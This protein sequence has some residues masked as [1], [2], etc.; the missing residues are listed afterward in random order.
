MENPLRNEIKSRAKSRRPG[1]HVRRFAANF[2]LRG[3]RSII[4]GRPAFTP[5]SAALCR[6]LASFLVRVACARSAVVSA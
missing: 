2:K 3:E 4:R 5:R 6:A 1:A